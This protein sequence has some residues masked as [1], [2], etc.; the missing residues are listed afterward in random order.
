MPHTRWGVEKRNGRL[1]FFFHF[2]SQ[3]RRAARPRR[4]R[5]RRRVDGKM[6][7]ADCQLGGRARSGRRVVCGV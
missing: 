5:P 1:H 3:D 4:V 7:T 2:M 6:S